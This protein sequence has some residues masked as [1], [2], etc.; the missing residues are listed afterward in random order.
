MAELGEFQLHR[1]DPAPNFALP[2]VDGR[3]YSL[4]DFQSSPFLL[5]TFWC[6]HCPYVQAWENRMIDL[7]RKYQPLG[8]SF[9]LI[10]SNDAVAYPSDAFDRMVDRARERKY[11]FPYLRDEAQSVARDYGALVTPHP[12]LFDSERRLLFQGRIDDNYQEPSRVRQTFLHDAL[13]AALEHRSIAK[14][15]VAV[16][17]CSVKW[18]S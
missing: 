9:V 12:M 11:P 8:V 14:P 15:E 6:N 16:L 18:R 2:S 3:T 1:G 7:G 5:V 10:N 4:Q 13:E 17:G